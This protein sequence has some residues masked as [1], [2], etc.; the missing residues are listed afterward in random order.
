MLA[1]LCQYL[2]SDF[3]DKILTSGQMCVTRE[4]VC[5]AQSFLRSHRDFL[6]N[7]NHQQLSLVFFYF[8]TSVQQLLEAVFLRLDLSPF[9]HANSASIHAHHIN[10]ALIICSKK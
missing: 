4:R 3:L 10:A 1:K 6:I 5:S 8:G 9:F 7:Y 2:V